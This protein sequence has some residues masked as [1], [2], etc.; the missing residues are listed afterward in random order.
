MAKSQPAVKGSFQLEEE[1]AEALLEEMLGNGFVAK[2]LAE[3]SC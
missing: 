2:T 1:R 3:G